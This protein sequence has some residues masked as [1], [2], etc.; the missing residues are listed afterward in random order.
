M[1]SDA[2]DPASTARLRLGA[3]MRR[4]RELKGLSRPAVHAQTGDDASNLA[5]WESGARNI[6]ADAMVRIDECY[7]TNGLLVALRDMAISIDHA[8]RVSDDSDRG[9]DKDMDYVR[10]QILAS[11]AVVGTSAVLPPLDALRHLMGPDRVQDWD[12][13]VWER[14][15]AFHTQPLPEL[16]KELAQDVLDV[17]QN[18]R[19]LDSTTSTTAARW[20]RINAQLLCL[21][22]R[23]LGSAGHPRHSRGWWSKAREAAELSG[24]VQL[25]AFILSKAA[26]QGL[27]EHRPVQ[28]LVSN[29]EEAL[30]VAQGVPCVGTALALAVQAQIRA[31]QGNAKGALTALKEQARIFTL[32]PSSV[33]DDHDSAF[34]WPEER[35]MHT[36]SFATI[37]GS[38]MPRDDEAQ[39]AALASYPETNARGR[40]Q[41]RLHEALHQVRI[42]D[43]VAGLDLAREA[44]S[45]LPAHDRTIFVRFD[46]EAVLTAVPE[47]LQ[48]HRQR[49]AA[50]EYQRTLALPP[51]TGLDA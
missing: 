19:R 13:I 20:H 38:N 40:A 26:I 18:L 27:Y 10:R 2:P 47:T 29:A 22:A 15:L 7:E 35:L 3:E 25:H 32:L 33:T 42:G 31:M 39:R 43:V 1:N 24:D 51:G 11:L 21:L 5:K 12:E 23:A 4:I 36:R 8:L 6:P 48:S 30:L 44:I 41:L 9:H 49:A 17:Q 16:I 28:V 50:V 14:A 34:G 46:A 45:S 37:Y